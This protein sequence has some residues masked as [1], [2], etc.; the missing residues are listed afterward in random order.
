[1]IRVLIADASSALTQWIGV[2]S[3]VIGGLA[4]VYVAYRTG[5]AEHQ[6]WLRQERLRAYGAFLEIAADG[7]EAIYAMLVPLQTS[8]GSP[9]EIV[10]RAE[11]TSDDL[12]RPA[13][14]IR[15]LGPDH[16]TE[17]AGAVRLS[18]GW[19]ALDTLEAIA[20]LDDDGELPVRPSAQKPPG[21]E[22][23]RRARNVSEALSHF[24]QVA[25]NEIQDRRLRRRLERHGWSRCH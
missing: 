14:R 10:R 7:L 9:Q 25:A 3:A 1:M 16:V 17:A 23:S 4:L 21:E 15:L 6:R 19:S 8:K 13:G 5:R 12:Q 2:V 24:N 20:E 22:L 18:L 11:Q